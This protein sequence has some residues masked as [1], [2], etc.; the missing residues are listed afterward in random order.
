MSRSEAS[1]CEEERMKDI[2]NLIQEA[3]EALKTAF[4]E[5]DKNEEADSGYLP[6]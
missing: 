4:E 5:I 2:E 3:E 6:E 1:C